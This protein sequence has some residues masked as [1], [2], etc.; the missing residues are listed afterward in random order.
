L[1]EDEAAALERST[2]QVYEIVGARGILR[3]A[4]VDD[5]ALQPPEQELL[6]EVV[7]FLR[8]E[9]DRLHEEIVDRLRL[10]ERSFGQRFF[11]SLAGG[12]RKVIGAYVLGVISVL[13]GLSVAWALNWIG[14]AIRSRPRQ[15][16]RRRR[17]SLARSLL[18]GEQSLQVVRVGRGRPLNS[19]PLRSLLATRAARRHFS[20]RAA[21]SN[22]RAV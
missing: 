17:R 4:V 16:H 7:G 2:K 12:S 19:S 8:G 14:V 13:A 9:A 15:L 22:P 10:R 21:G 18:V 6:Q 11:K 5:H 3:R 1:N 20:A